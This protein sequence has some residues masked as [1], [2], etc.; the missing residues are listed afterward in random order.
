MKAFKVLARERPLRPAEGA[1]D[2]A[3]EAAFAFAED[4]FETV[5]HVVAVFVA[6]A[7]DE[8]LAVEAVQ[9]ARRGRLGDRFVLDFRDEELEEDWP[10]CAEELEDMA[11]TALIQGNIVVGSEALEEVKGFGLFERGDFA[12]IEIIDGGGEPE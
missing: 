12:D 4:V 8:A 3:R 2:L 7:A 10:V 6:A 9:C 5:E 1:E 11:A